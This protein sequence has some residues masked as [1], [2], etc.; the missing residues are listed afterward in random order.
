MKTYHLI[1][2]NGGKTR[3][4][5]LTVFF[6]LTGTM[7]VQAY[8]YNLW[9]G[10][11][12]VTSS[13]R[14][15]V[16]GGGIQSG[17]V[18][19]EQYSSYDELTLTD[20]TIYVNS[21]DANKKYAIY[22]KGIRNLR[23]IFKGTNVIE[24]VKGAT[25]M[26][27]EQTRL[28]VASGRTDI[29]GNVGCIY[30]NGY[31]CEIFTTNNC[32]LFITGD[33]CAAIE[34]NNTG[35]TSG[36]VDIAGKNIELEGSKGNLVNLN[37]VRFYSYSG[38]GCDVKLVSTDNS[39]Y[40]SV[41]NVISMPNNNYSTASSN[42]PVI[43]SPS[44]AE[45]NSSKKS[46]CYSNGNR[47][48][49][50]NIVINNDFVYP[51]S[52]KIFPDAN[53]RSYL[54]DRF[55]VVI[56]QTQIDN[57]TDIN[58]RG[59]SIGS[60]MGI[61]IFTELETLNCVD[62]DLTVLDLDF[63]TKLIGVECDYNQL[64]VLYVPNTLQW[65]GCS[66]NYLNSFLRGSTFNKLKDL[67]CSYNSAMTNLGTN[68]SNLSALENFDCSGTKFSTLD[69]SSCKKLKELTCENNTNL[70]SLTCTGTALTTLNLSGCSALKTVNSYN[71]KLTYIDV[72]GCSSLQKLDCHGNQLTSVAYMYSCKPALEELYIQSNNLTSLDLSGYSKLKYLYCNTNL[73]TS[74]SGLTN[75]TTLYDII[76]YG[77]ELT[78]L[79]L[80]GC[81]N[82]KSVDCK[83]NPLTT[84][85][86]TGLSK[87]QTLNCSST[88][89]TSLD[90]NASAF[91]NLRE[92]NCNSC[93]LQ[94]IEWYNLKL[95]TLN[96]SY[97]TNLTSLD[98]SRDYS[99]NANPLTTLDIKGCTALKEIKIYC[100]S[101][102]SINLSSCGNLEYLYCHNNHLGSLN[103]SNCGSLTY[104]DCG[105][106]NLETLNLQYN[107]N[108]QELY[109]G[110]NSITSLNVKGLTNLCFLHCSNNRL[111][112][113]DLRGCNALEQLDCD[114]N[115]I[116]SLI[117]PKENTVLKDVICDYNNLE[118]VMMDVFV[119]SL[120]DRN[121]KE[122]GFLLLLGVDSDEH[123]VCTSQNIRDAN[124]KNWNTFIRT[125]DGSFIPYS[126]P[127]GATTIRTADADVD[128]NAPRYNMSGQRVGRD[129]KGVVIVN[130]RKVVK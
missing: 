9:V 1:K 125:D 34:G 84:L 119:E 99:N 15:N 122:P 85:N 10:G 16:T 111:T 33:G 12:R 92:V 44:K 130:G 114:R 7:S 107:S 74:L 20:V 4:F 68:F 30:I 89:L 18:K 50:D 29:F 83:I 109:C 47:I 88:K 117:L 37:Q 76:C 65:L 6:L 25:V 75:N 13:N 77:N 115:Q 73:L 62:N 17:T 101:L 23:V 110:S 42:T 94:K 21:T 8:D 96:C 5:L 91:P 64:T 93:K 128:A 95:T 106:N 31:D 124:S 127:G 24:A 43:V 38:S 61:G 87:L 86:L 78:S 11:V 3:L 40:P 36:N 120:P 63:N 32:S 123:N 112:L 22:N 48:Y 80:S 90:L 104:L 97:N 105:G 103:V 46:I 108:I 113:L 102:T 71:N 49:N 60:L 98:N 27:N 70:T 55:G 129:Y 2:S 59:K 28:E 14:N 56:K 51:V 81:T 67:N 19:F 57:C 121:N 52:N 116:E 66:Y 35:E 58:V 69:V 41:N 100:N 26:C 82:L 54:V 39:S 126:G 79:N 53:F 118:G 45:F 72:Y